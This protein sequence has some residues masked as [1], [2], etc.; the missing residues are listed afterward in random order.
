MEFVNK[1][2]IRID[3]EINELDKTTFQ[4][5]KILEKHVNYVIVSG[6]VAILLGRNRSTEDVDVIIPKID[7][8]KLSL[9]YDSLIEEGYWCLN[10]SDIE[11]LYQLLISKS[12][13]RFAPEP[14]ISPNFEIKFSK[15]IYDEMAMKNPVIM[16]LG[17][18]KLKT[19]FLELQIAFKE[20]VLK[21]NK[22]IE[23]ANHIRLVASGHLD[24][25]LI[26]EY[27]RKLRN[28]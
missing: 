26:N 7:K 6:Y 4:F 17:N 22:D 16:Q 10:T 21:S 25:N 2:M 12:S 13:I 24:E 9:I 15:D 27:K 28:R 11:D 1:N 8:Q 19:S 18:E 14:R 5:V 23:D 20:E 3:K